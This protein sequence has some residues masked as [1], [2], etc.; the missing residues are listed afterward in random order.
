M[1]KYFETIDGK[2]M[3]EGHIKRAFTIMFP[4]EE[5]T[6]EKITTLCK[7]I[8]GEFIPTVDE[9]IKRDCIVFA[10]KLYRELNS[11]SL[12]EAH[13]AVYHMRDELRGNT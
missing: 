9:F 5:Y 3:S 1:E 7:G 8:K 6:R 13:T 10:V 11:C 4:N 12:T 2:I